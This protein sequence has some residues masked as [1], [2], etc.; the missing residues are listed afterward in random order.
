MNF[1]NYHSVYLLGIGGI[2]MSALARYF[3]AMGKEVS[4]YDRTSTPLT[5]RLEEEGIKIDFED[6]TELISQKVIEDKS[7]SLIIYTPAIPADHKQ[8]NHFI[9]LG[10]KLYKRSEV[11]GMIS[12]AH[13]CIA[14]A[15]THGKT[16]VSS[17]IAYILSFTGRNV[18]AFVGGI[19]K[20]YGSNFILGEPK[21]EDHIVLAEA[22]EYD[23]S[24][25]RLS[26]N[27]AVITSA[28][29]D[30]LDIYG[31]ESGIKESFRDFA[32]IAK[33]KGD[34]FIQSDLEHDFN[35]FEYQTYG[36]ENGD[37]HANNLRIEDGTFIFDV[38]LHGELHKDFQLHIPGFHNVEN[39]LAALSVC[40]KLGID[41]N[42]IKEAIAHYSGVKRRMDLI[43][44]KS[45][46]IYIDD[47]A[48]H[49][50]EIR[51]LIKSI[52]S[53]YPEK[54]ITVIFQPHLFSRTRDFAKG[55]SE[56][57]SLADRVILLPIYPAREL[58]IPG[59]DS[60]MLLKDILT[61]KKELLEKEEAINAVKNI[62]KGVL[63]TVG[64][65]D[66]DQLVNQIKEV[67]E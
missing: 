13:P 48:H 50:T 26:P 58:P 8:R 59:V 49:P 47:Y 24:F 10:H 41:T 1:N 63:L 37:I 4:G 5:T 52:R 46:I 6:N 22:D 14:V 32:S 66:I 19:M 54:E 28:E 43:V 64:A 23:R 65:G 12:A 57:L 17:I 61:D 30:H 15:G 20:N 53:L 35:G 21:S 56:S 29:A 3:N 39:T 25:L 7:G 31:E 45:D 42:D 36:L 11:L 38:N 27:Y 33:E 55:F 16:S 67:L 51:A 62:D 2:G 34:L 60:Q 9:D 18:T 44:R 40:H